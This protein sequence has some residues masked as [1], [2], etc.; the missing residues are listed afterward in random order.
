MATLSIRDGHS[1]VPHLRASVM[2]PLMFLMP[3]ILLATVASYLCGPGTV[4]IY[5]C[6]MR[7]YELPPPSRIMNAHALSYRPK[8]KK[9]K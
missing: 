9:I 2:R 8:K 7:N 4:S 5:I 6:E 3:P 1:T